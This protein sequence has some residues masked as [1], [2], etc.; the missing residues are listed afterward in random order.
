MKPSHVVWVCAIVIAVVIAAC[1]RFSIVPAA[2][3][4]AAARKTERAILSPPQGKHV[5]SA[6]T[7]IPPGGQIQHLGNVDERTLSTW[8]SRSK[9][10]PLLSEFAAWVEKARH[11][12]GPITEN[13][14]VALAEQRRERLAKLIQTDPRRALELA[15]P[16][17]LIAALP[18]RVAALAEEHVAG[19]G[20]LAVLGAI[21]EKPGTENF[22]GTFRVATVDGRA[23]R[24]FA[25]GRRLGEPTRDDILLHGIAVKSPTHG[26]LLA[27]H[28]SPARLLGGA[29]VAQLKRNGGAD[30]LCAVSGLPSM[31]KSAQTV[32]DL[33]GEPVFACDPNHALILQEQIAA[34][35]GENAASAVPGAPKAATYT[36]GRKRLLFIRVDFADFPGPPL[37][38]LEGLQLITNMNNYWVDASYGKTTVAMPGQGFGQSSDITPTLRLTNNAFY[39]T[40]NNFYDALRA[41]ARA[42]ADAAGFY[43]TNYEFDITCIGPVPGFNWRGLGYVGANGAWIRGS[44]FTGTIAHELG[45]NLGLNHANFWDTSNTSAI[46]PG[47]SVEYGDG[48]DVMGSDGSVRPYNARYRAY[49]NWLT[50]SDVATF[51]TNGIY[52]IMAFD[53]T[54]STGVRALKIIRNAGSDST[55][56]YWLEYHAMAQANQWE[57]TGA[58]L[59]WA[60]SGNHKSQLIDTTPGSPSGLGDVPIAIGRTF[61]DNVFKLYITPLRKAGTTP[62]SLDLFV[63]KGTLASNLSPALSISATTTNPSVLDS[64]IFTATAT[65]SNGDVLAYHWD[66]GDSSFG[67]NGNVIGKSWS[68]AGEYVVLCTVTDMKGGEARSR[69]IVRVGSPATYRISGRVLNDGNPVQGVRVFA[70]STHVTYTDSSGNYDLVNLDAGNYTVGAVLEGYTFTNS[71]FVNPVVVGPN[72]QNIDFISIPPHYVFPN[73][74]ITNPVPGAIFGEGS[75]V[76]ISATASAL[77]GRSITNVEFFISGIKLAEAAAAPYDVTWSNAIFGTYALTARAIDSTGVAVTSAPVTIEISRTIFARGSVWKYLDDG[78]DQG[79]NWIMPDFDDGAWASG[80]GRFGYGGD[81]EATTVGYGPNANAKHITTYFRRAFELPPGVIVSNLIVRWTRDDGVVAYADGAEAFRDNVQDGP[82]TFLTTASTDVT[83]GDETNFFEMTLSGALLATNTSTHVLAVEVRQAAPDSDDLGFDLELIATGTVVPRLAIRRVGSQLELSW[84]AMAENWNLYAADS[85][86]PAAQW[87]P[88]TSVTVVNGMKTVTIS[89]YQ[90]SGFY[91][92]QNP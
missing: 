19:R 33:G 77:D 6:S 79:T 40:T 21:P 75:D 50:A 86:S 24:A 20:R 37:T 72:A 78:S 26:H 12:D 49:L 18:P 55:N 1:F 17:D 88:V 62:E 85:M 34:A 81:G 76:L 60:G 89:A 80:A 84:P 59:R 69:L 8:L 28:E 10:E 68:S 63:F 27:V 15:M 66:F 48:F 38:D 65:D 58:E 25:Y 39:Y 90:L 53:V 31:T 91:R 5:G 30:P 87:L 70:S 41:A 7:N 52:R 3:N 9:E 56:Q 23:Y 2:H 43:R 32:L 29:E 45:H 51:S 46:G 83:N 35:D 67:T 82:I 54:N 13:E 22:E 4:D 16:K 42:A 92:L 64:V 73:V 14:G 47:R 61:V 36:E 57:Q 74:A 44:F 11:G 71:G